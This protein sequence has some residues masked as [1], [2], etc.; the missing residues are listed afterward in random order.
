[1]AR[2]VGVRLVIARTLEPKP[3][4][5]MLHISFRGFQPP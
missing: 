3:G 1:M 5:A 4:E 2:K